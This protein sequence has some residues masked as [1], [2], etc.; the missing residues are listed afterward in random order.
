MNYLKISKK[1]LKNLQNILEN[2][3]FK[4]NK[5]YL[6]EFCEV[7]VEN[8]LSDQN[9]FF[10]RT[11]FMT[12]VIFVSDKCKNGDIINVKINSFNQN[13]LFG[14]HKINNNEKAA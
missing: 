1:R 10:G 3:Q 8:K 6:D 7:L 14:F 5:I 9:K 2:F 12:P 11:R 13:N 4:S